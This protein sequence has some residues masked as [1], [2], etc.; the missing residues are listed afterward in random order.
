MGDNRQSASVLAFGRNLRL[1][2]LVVLYSLMGCF[3]GVFFGPT[4][5]WSTPYQEMRTHLAPVSDRM[6]DTMRGGFSAGNLNVSFGIQ[7]VS[8]IN[9]QVFEQLNLNGVSNSSGT[10]FTSSSFQITPL[11]QN[12][13]GTL[14]NIVSSGINN[15][16]SNAVTQTQGIVTVI[17]NTHN[18]VT[19]QFQTQVN[20]G[21]QNITSMVQTTSMNNRLVFLH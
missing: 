13:L 20:M 17:Q 11:S 21:L 2:K 10:H 12:A 7:S 4:L 8:I 15:A 16:V 3:L 18:N 14:V 9:G 19:M 1:G 6:L 5:A